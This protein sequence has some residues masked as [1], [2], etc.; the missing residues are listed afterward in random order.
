MFEQST[1]VRITS[2]ELVRDSVNPQLF[3]LQC[4]TSPNMSAQWI[5]ALERRYPGPTLRPTANGFQ[6]TIPIGELESAEDRALSLR[7]AIEA[8]NR[9]IFLTTEAG[10]QA[11]MDAALDSFHVI[12]VEGDS[13]LITLE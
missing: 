12:L 10:A 4:T 13:P 1:D 9:E 8:T 6:I 7:D 3:F 2:V 5:E 11:A